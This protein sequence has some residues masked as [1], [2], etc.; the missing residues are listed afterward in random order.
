M[1][2]LR[3]KYPPGR[4]PRRGAA[5]PAWSGHNYGFSIDIDVSATMENLGMK[6]KRALDAW[7]AWNGFHCH[8]KDHKR[9][10]EE[11]HY[12]ALVVGGLPW[13]KERGWTTASALEAMIRSTYGEHW[14]MT[15][16]Q[17]QRSLKLL[18]LYPGD[19]DGKFGPLSRQAMVSFQKAWHLKPTGQADT[20]T[21]RVLAF[22]C[23]ELRSPLLKNLWTV[24]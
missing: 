20:G 5:K 8:R 3:K 19:I 16:K 18:G 2:S 24:A 23:A 7:M 14:N 21:Q 4:L 13:H 22:R 15:R 6:N 1:I 9:K 10:R 11:W 12:N 17:I